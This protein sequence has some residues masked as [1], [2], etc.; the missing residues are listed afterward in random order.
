MQRRFARPGSCGQSD[1]RYERALNNQGFTIRSEDKKSGAAIGAA[2]EEFIR[3][4]SP[5]VRERK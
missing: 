1:I 2:P 4:G 3:R 5:G